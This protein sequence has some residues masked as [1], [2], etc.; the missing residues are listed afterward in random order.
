VM[1]YC[2]TSPLLAVCETEACSVHCAILCS[3]CEIRRVQL[4]YRSGT[5]TSTHAVHHGP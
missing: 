2:I 3:V 1:R 5:T 4:R